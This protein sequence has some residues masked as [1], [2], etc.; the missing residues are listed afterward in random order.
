[1][2]NIPGVQADET[3]RS[4]GGFRPVSAEEMGAGTGEALERLG[5]TVASTA[6]EL[7]DVHQQVKAHQANTSV[8]QQ[9]ND[10]QQELKTG[11]VNDGS[12]ID[13]KTGQPF[14]VGSPQIDQATGL[15]VGPPPPEKHAE[16][17]QQK[18]D[19][20][21]ET[22]G[23]SFGP[24][25][26]GAQRMFNANFDQHAN[27]ALLEAKVHATSL[28]SDTIR[29]NFQLDLQNRANLSVN[30][31]PLVRHTSEHETEQY[32]DTMVKRGVVTPEQAFQLKENFVEQVE[33][34]TIRNIMKQPPRAD[35]TSGA[36]DVIKAIDNGEFNGLKADVLQ[37]NREIALNQDYQNRHRA[38]EDTEFKQRQ[39]DHARSEASRATALQFTNLLSQHNLTPDIVRAAVAKGSISPEQAMVFT[40]AAAGGDTLPDDSVT[41]NALVNRI[42]NGEDVREDIGSASG[43]GKLSP[44]GAIELYR[45]DA[46]YSGTMK[47][48]PADKENIQY[49]HGMMGGDSLTKLPAQN[50]AEAQAKQA[51]MDYV[52]DN[53]K[54][55]AADRRAQAEQIIQRASIFDK[56][57]MPTAM[58][59]PRFYPGS[60][61][62][63]LQADPT[64]RTA[65]LA[66]AVATTQAK[67][68]SGELTQD[69]GNRELKRIGQWAKQFPAAV[70]PAAGKVKK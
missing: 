53:P 12:Q 18:I 39:Q 19:E 34:G 52:R 44:N 14:P 9:L 68:K 62:D 10:F 65:G 48:S 35:G 56:Q 55:T 13:P 63:L 33:L 41:K 32:I 69:E 51:Y 15:P 23:G 66:K 21:R 29:S 49:I 67:M 30:A 64:T 7:Y 2:P 50:A 26:G 70:A 59:A 28:M 46:E 17:M 54:T 45:L 57:D 6:D 20:L 36:T 1:M 11:P 22:Y 24:L 27:A 4:P 47:G 42:F 16:L 25:E 38:I 60:K 43:S 40:K 37:R 58:L 5:Q 61:A 3:L 8:Q 31:D